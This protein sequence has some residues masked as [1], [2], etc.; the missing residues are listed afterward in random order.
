MVDGE[1]VGLVTD[2]DHLT[3]VELAD[4]SVV[5]RTAVF[6]RP[7]NVPHP[8]GL[9]AGLGVD[10]DSGGFPVVDRDGTTSTPGVWAAGN[11]VDPRGSVIAAAGAA[12]TAAMAINAN[13]VFDEGKGDQT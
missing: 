11:I 10:V 4:G 1:V 6:I 2:E 12:A 5:P 13:L 8:D 7:H 9:L 3:G